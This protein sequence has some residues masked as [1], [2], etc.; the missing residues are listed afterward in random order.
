LFGAAVGYYLRGQEIRRAETMARIDDIA[1]QLDELL[2][3][4]KVYWSKD[5]Q[6]GAVPQEFIALE[7]EIL[8][9]LHMVSHLVVAVGARAGT[10]AQLDLDDHLTKLRQTI[11]G[12]AFR[13]AP[14]E[15]DPARL[16]AVFASAGDFVSAGRSV[17]LRFLRGAWPEAA[18]QAGTWL[19]RL[20]GSFCAIAARIRGWFRSDGT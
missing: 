13:S 17:G 8:G 11:T 5:R 15:A 2:E 20:P 16:Q 6:E 12:G 19:I 7:A 3:A 18:R 9:R 10:A 1:G 4:A 14:R